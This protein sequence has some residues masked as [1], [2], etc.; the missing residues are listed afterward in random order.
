MD[1][2]L[3]NYSVEIIFCSSTL[4]DGKE[5]TKKNY[6]GLTFLSMGI[7]RHWVSTPFFQLSPSVPLVSILHV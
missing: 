4:D 2:N 6:D 7:K 3:N 1:I 5:I